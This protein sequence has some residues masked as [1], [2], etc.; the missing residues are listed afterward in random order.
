MKKKKDLQYCTKIES[1]DTFEFKQ[2]WKVG[3]RYLLS[4]LVHYFKSCGWFQCSFRAILSHLFIYHQINI[5]SSVDCL[6]IHYTSW[7]RRVDVI[8]AFRK[9]LCKS[10][11]S[12][13]CYEPFSCQNWE[14][15]ICTSA[16]FGPRVFYQNCVSKYF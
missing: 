12:V 1:F 8:Y 15:A 9:E 5:S 10:V 4:W 7:P 2:R 11:H 14:W 3:L 13:K 16:F 6:R